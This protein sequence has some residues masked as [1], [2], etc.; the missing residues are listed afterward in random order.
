MVFN[1]LLISSFLHLAL[2]ATENFGGLTC[3][4]FSEIYS[5]GTDMCTTMWSNSFTVPGTEDVYTMGFFDATNPNT[6][7]SNRHN[8]TDINGKTLNDYINPLTSQPKCQLEDL[9]MPE[10]KAMGLGNYTQCHSFHESACC[11]KKTITSFETVNAMYG[12]QYHIDRC[13]PMSDEC[14]NFFM[15]EA[16]FYECDPNAGL[17]RMFSDAQVQADL[18]ENGTLTWTNKWQMHGMPIRKGFCDNWFAACYNDYFCAD[19]GGDFFSCAAEYKAPPTEAEK[20]LASEQKWNAFL[21]SITVIFVFVGIL[22][23]S[24]MA[25]LIYR[26]KAGRS[27]FSPLIEEHEPSLGRKTSGGNS[28]V[29]KPAADEDML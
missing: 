11:E 19:G 20:Q 12:Q 8:V 25:Y 18:A 6:V 15:M 16:C 13:G 21:I 28:R 2:S 29:L 24:A 9:Q 23:I 7:Y 17:F 27:V 4:K 22:S 14:K 10:A 26:E 3:K 5:D 1:I